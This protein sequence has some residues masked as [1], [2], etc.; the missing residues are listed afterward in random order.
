MRIMIDT[1]VLISALIF[2]STKLAKLIEYITEKHSL[3]L[4]SYVIEE[5]NVVIRKKSPKYIAVL[6]RFL[7]KISFEMVYTPSDMTI[8]PKIR[9]EEDIPVI[10]SAIAS[11]VDILITGDK[12]FADLPIERPEILTPSEFISKYWM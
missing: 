10:V 11:D 7:L 9:D 4:C 1:N 6:D 2:K 8:T 12:D 5:A 3:V